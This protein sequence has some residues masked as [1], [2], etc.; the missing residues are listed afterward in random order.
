MTN[1]KELPLI[2]S[3]QWMKITSS[4]ILLWWI[5]IYVC[6]WW[7]M[8]ARSPSFFGGS[9]CMIC[10]Q[11]RWMLEALWSWWWGWLIMFSTWFSIDLRCMQ[12]LE[13]ICV[14]LFS[15]FIK[16]L[17]KLW[18]TIYRKQVKR[19]F[20]T[21]FQNH[22]LNIL[23]YLSLVTSRSSNVNYNILLQDLWHILQDYF[24]KIYI[25]EDT[26]HELIKECFPYY[27]KIHL[28]KCIY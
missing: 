21:M 27:K 17:E 6:M 8:M 4:P 25:L 20:Q 14:F 24:G 2:E 10:L 22:V 11:Q 15:C 23:L 13:R 1:L 7:M 9:R 19:F 26:I 16:L 28:D 5:F 18:A 12:S 3:L